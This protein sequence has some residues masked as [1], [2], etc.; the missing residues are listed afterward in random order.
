MTTQAT[1][2]LRRCAEAARP[3]GRVVVLGGVTED[4]AR[5]GLMIEMVLLGGKY[6]TVAELRRLAQQVGLTVV[7]AGQ[8]PSG[9]F[10]VECR[11]V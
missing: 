5:V 1:V 3:N 11:P 9:H 2:I 10:V 7:A 8:Q 6:R 4:D